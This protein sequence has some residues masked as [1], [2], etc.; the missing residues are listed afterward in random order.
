MSIGAGPSRWL[1]YDTTGFVAMPWRLGSVIA[2]IAPAEAAPVTESQ[3]TLH[4]L[5]RLIAIELVG[6][7]GVVRQVAATLRAGNRVGLYCSDPQV[8]YKSIAWADGG[9]VSFYKRLPSGPVHALFLHPQALPGELQSQKPVYAVARDTDQT[10]TYRMLDTALP[11][12][13][14]PSWMPYLLDA[15]R[16]TELIHELAGDGLWALEIVPDVGRW[17]TLLRRGLTTGALRWDS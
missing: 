3:R 16:E 14:L 6:S 17:A 2:P 13:L 4:T 15:G 11:I 12:P 5:D 8:A 10:H 9:L 1:T 7:Q